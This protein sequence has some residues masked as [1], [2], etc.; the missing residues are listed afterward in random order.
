MYSSLNDYIR[1]LETHG[2]LIRITTPVDP[3]LEIAEIT[4]R[5][6]KRR[7]GGRALLFEATGTDFPVL[8]NMMGSDRR[9]ALALGVERL[10]ELPERIDRLFGSLTTPKHNLWE[11]LKMLPLL[12]Q[13]AR[14]MP[15]H[16]RGRGACQEVVWQDEALDLTR[17][18]ILKCWPHD[19]D[20]FI[21]LPLVHT[22]DPESGVRNVGMYRMQCFGPQETGMHW[23]LHKTGER[24]Y[25]GYRDQKR[26]MP[27]SVCLGG[28]P[29]YTYAA[30]APMPDN[31]DE[32]LL[33]G[34][35]RQRPVELVQCLTNELRVP[36]DC[37]FV[38]EGYVDP[39]EERVCEGPFGDHTGFYS[40]EDLY[41]RFHL[42]ALTH[43]RDAVYPATLVGVPP[44][45]DAYIAKATEKI[46]LIPIRRTMLPEV[47]DLYMPT[48]GV[49]H[50]LALVD[51]TPRY[52]GQGAKV[53][54]SLWGAGQM[55]FNK[56][57][58][59]I[60]GANESLRDPETL[61]RRLR[62]LRVPE[63]VICAR[64]PLDV[65]D[66]AAPQIGLGGKLA[67]DLTECRLDEPA[68]PITLPE[69]WS[70]DPA[71]RSVDHTLTEAWGVLFL[72][73]AEGSTPDPQAYLERHHATGIPLVILLAE[74][75]ASLTPQERLWITTAHC[76]PSRDLH[77]AHHTLWID[78]RVKAG[79][80][81]GFDRRWPNVVTASTETIAQVDRR[82]DT[83][84]LG[85]FAPSPSLRYL[86]L[87]RRDDAEYDAQ[88]SLHTNP[89]KP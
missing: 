70:S 68:P 84:G 76:D 49:A 9:M 29:A 53:A 5:E 3:L 79:G 22:V 14:W 80:I 77:M 1:T 31:L 61:R 83:Y 18:P 2:E 73:A 66:H 27:V 78:A 12:E 59:L 19:A 30:T 10:E 86:T 67:L 24:H 25:Q 65:L 58:V 28:D 37:D 8:T 42:T 44:Q 17:L 72:Y 38:L 88:P 69:A 51:L 43:R 33:A 71:I 55:M 15:R 48:P 23:H 60:C 16:L 62:R 26:R 45:E 63:E 21:T 40:L 4:D 34:F 82:W 13:M 32:Y 11:K 46:F 39:S 87:Q 85:A 89:P 35:L 52:P 54:S 74:A 57:M 6:S 81:N 56:F 41:P 75:T 64:G 50:N 47:N 20:R 7:D 36:A